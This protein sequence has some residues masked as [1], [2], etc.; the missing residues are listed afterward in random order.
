MAVAIQRGER[1]DCFRGLCIEFDSGGL[2][3]HD[4]KTVLGFL[5][6][7]C[8][9]PETGHRCEG[10]RHNHGVAILFISLQLVYGDRLC[11]RD[12]RFCT[13]ALALVIGRLRAI[14]Y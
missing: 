5:P 8:V 6:A 9:L 2:L 11:L 10:H 3:E 13:K 1:L 12:F 4:W 14:T 7:C